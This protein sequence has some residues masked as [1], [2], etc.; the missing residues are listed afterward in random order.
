[1]ILKIILI[2]ELKFVVENLENTGKQK[3]YIILHIITDINILLVT[4]QF[5]TFSH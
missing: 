3:R 5:R 2:T 1:M 4:E